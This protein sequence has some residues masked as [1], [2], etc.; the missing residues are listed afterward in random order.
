MSSGANSCVRTIAIAN[1]VSQGMMRSTPFG[2]SPRQFGP[3]IMVTPAPLP[4]VRLPA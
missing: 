4:V 2:S 1:S 3:A